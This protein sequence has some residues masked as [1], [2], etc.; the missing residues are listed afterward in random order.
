MRYA[1]SVFFKFDEIN[2]NVFF[3][4]NCDQ[5]EINH[6]MENLINEN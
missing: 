1:G 4:F 2:K 3:M 6:A 5:T